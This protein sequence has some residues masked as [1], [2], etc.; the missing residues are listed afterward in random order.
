M[1]EVVGRAGFHVEHAKPVAERGAI[2]HEMMREL[3]EDSI[4]YWAERN[5]NIVV[6]DESLNEAMVNDGSGGF[7]LCLDRREVLEYGMERVG[8]LR[9]KLRE[10]AP[11]PKTGK[12]QGGTVTSTLIVSHLPKSMCREIPDYYPVLDD[13]TGEPVEDA[14]GEPM[15]RSRWVARD[16]DEARRYFE[17]VIDYLAEQVIPGGQQAILGYDIQHSESTPH[18]QVLADTFGPDPKHPGSLRVDASRAWF[19]HRDVRDDRGRQKS[20]KAKLSEYHAGLKK[21]LLDLGYDISPDFDEKRH[22]TGMGK[23]EYG[24]TQDALRVVEERQEGVVEQFGELESSVENTRVWFEDQ[25]ADLDERRAV[26]AEAEAELPRKRRKAVQE[27]KAEGLAAAEK[28]INA[29]VEEKVQ[30]IVGPAQNQAARLLR[31]AE[32]EK[33]R[34]LEAA[35]QRLAQILAAARQDVPVLFEEFLDLPTKNGVTPRG[36]FERFVDRRLK[37]FEAEH[38]VTDQLIL[39]QGDREA[40]IADGGQQLAVDVARLQRDREYGE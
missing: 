7:G 15:R 33:S 24:R 10:D 25:H 37:K 20:G 40:F 17:D 2:L 35:E 26:L 28:V 14:S 36:T 8:R 34:A 3:E 23:D 1:G 16:R 27:G 21:H 38:G 6:A 30:E 12:M 11:D 13:K 9:R 32:E 19:S 39:E 5:P 31:E 18:V 22:L 29:A 4:A